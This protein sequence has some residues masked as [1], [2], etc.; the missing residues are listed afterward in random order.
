MC[1]EGRQ[2]FLTHSPTHLWGLRFAAFL[3]LISN[4]AQFVVEVSSI[5][6]FVYMCVCVCGPIY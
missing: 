1:R 4:D 5:E 2:I 6:S 3:R